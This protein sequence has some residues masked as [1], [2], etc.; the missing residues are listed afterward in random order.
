MDLSEY[1]RKK[2]GAST[3]LEGILPNAVFDVSPTK[4]VIF[5]RGNLQFRKQGTHE[6][7]EG[8]KAGV[9]R[10]AE[11]QY[12]YIGEGNQKVSESYTG[13][14]DL[15]GWGTSGWE[16][17]DPWMTKK[18][19]VA[20]Y[21]HGNKLPINSQCDCSFGDWGVYNAISNGGNAPGLWRSLTE[22]EMSYLL[23]HNGGW[24]L[25][26]AKAKLCMLLFPKSFPLNQYSIKTLYT[27]SWNEENDG[28]MKLVKYSAEQFSEM[29]KYGVVALPCA[30]SRTDTSLGWIGMGGSIWS[31]SVNGEGRTNV[32]WFSTKE[33]YTGWSNARFYGRSVRLIHDL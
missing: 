29:E 8:T 13:W 18:G 20:Y 14:I 6:T 25:A 2:V 15:F 32:L 5:S 31:S 3:E 10:F 11:N 12:D 33:A 22:E 16:N 30:G 9:W 21:P 23:T 26:Y 1:R 27:R 7:V 19:E 28:K 24:T 4:K 17:R